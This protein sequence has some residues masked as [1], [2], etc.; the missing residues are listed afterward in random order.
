[1]EEQTPD[2]AVI[3]RV[4]FHCASCLGLGRAEIKLVRS[5]LLCCRLVPSSSPGLSFLYWEEENGWMEMRRK[6]PQG[7]TLLLAGCD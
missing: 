5:D 1:M 6:P 4:I 3:D 2:K 7:L